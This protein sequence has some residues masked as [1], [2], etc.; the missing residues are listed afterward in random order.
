MFILALA[1]GKSIKEL[2][3]SMDTKEFFMWWNYYSERPFG[4]VRADYRVGLNT[5]LLLTPHLKESRPLDNFILLFKDSTPTNEELYGKL[6][7][8]FGNGK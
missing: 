5:Q 6:K 4:D 2:M 8:L 7:G 1:L 3:A